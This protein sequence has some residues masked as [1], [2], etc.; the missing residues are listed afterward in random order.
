MPTEENFLYLFF[1]PSDLSQAA[2]HVYWKRRHEREDQDTPS[3]LK[4]MAA[5]A[6]AIAEWGAVPARDRYAKLKNIALPVLVVNG[7]T[8][9]MVPTVNSFI[10]QQHL[11]DAELLIYP[12]FG[13]GAIFQFPA[14]F[15]REATTFLDR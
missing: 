15:V 6:R 1:Y 7:K 3:S 2:G 12:D 14:Q 5:Q 11:P 8:D 13:H 9:L 10:L 4:A